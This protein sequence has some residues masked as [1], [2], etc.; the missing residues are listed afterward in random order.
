MDSGNASGIGILK[1]EGVEM[2]PAV[3]A[4][5]R[6]ALAVSGVTDAATPGPN[7]VEERILFAVHPRLDEVKS[8]AGGL[9][10]LPQLVARS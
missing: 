7:D 4:V 8:L 10:L 6:L 9:A 3:V 1:R 2:N 5:A